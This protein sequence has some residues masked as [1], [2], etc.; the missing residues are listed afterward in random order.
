MFYI[1]W[2]KITANDGESRL[3]FEPGLNIIYG[4]SN[5]GKSMV[6][7]CIDYMMG[8]KESSFDSNLKVQNVAIG[9]DANGNALSI[10][11]EVNSQEFE[12]I[13]HVEGID[14]GTY[15]MKP[16]KKFGAINSVWLMLMGISTDIRIINSQEGKSQSLTARTFYHTYMIDEDRIHNKASILK[17]KGTNNSVSTSTLTALLYLGTGNN[18]LSKDSFIDPKIKKAKDESVKGVVDRGMGFLERQKSSFDEIQ[19]SMQPDELRQKIDQTIDEIGATKGILKDVLHSRKVI[20][21]ELN[22]VIDEMAEDEVL[23]ERNDRLLLQYQSDVKRL[24]FI[25]EGNIVSQDLKPSVRCPFCNGELPHEHKEDCIGAAIN[26]VQKIEKQVKDLQ[27]VQKALKEEYSVLTKRKEN[28][29]EQSE[30]QSVKISGELNPKIKRLKEQ[31]DEYQSSLRF[32]EMQEMITSFSGFL[33]EERDAVESSTI[34]NNQLNAKEKFKEVFQKLLDAELK[35]LLVQCAYQ[36]YIDS[37]F[38]IASCD[39]VVNGHKKKS[40]GKGFRAFLNTI[41]AVAIQNC[42][43]KMGHYHPALLI[44][45]SPILTLKEKDVSKDEFVPDPMKSGLFRYF[46]ERKSPPQTIIIENE[47][48]AIDYGKANLIRFTKDSKTGRYG[49]IEGYQE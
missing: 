13:S 31:L 11:R 49:L 47:I 17:G 28:L 33:K 35:D 25:A 45:D 20:G 21:D 32:Y 42:L 2:L 9:I 14:S 5:S 43:E 38:D 24:T 40:Q 10:S 18:Y 19:P 34:T 4:P 22:K 7:D 44:V 29:F 36:N 1:K 12:V 6:L 46:V 15:K 23:L 26:E 27:S 48:P 16:S 39:V 8:A 37:H 3:M 41:L 30:E